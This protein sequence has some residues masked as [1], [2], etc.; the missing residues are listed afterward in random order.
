MYKIES[1]SRAGDIDIVPANQN[2]YV[3]HLFHR[4]TCFFHVQKK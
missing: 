1:L 3:V 4:G 2:Y